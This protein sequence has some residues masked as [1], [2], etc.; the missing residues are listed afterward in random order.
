[1]SNV[2]A[3]NFAVLL[4]PFIGEVPEEGRPRFLA[5]L[6]RGAAE[7]YRAWAR[8]LP[9]HAGTLLAC[10]EREDEIADRVEAVFPVAAELEK[11]VARPLPRARDVYYDVFAGMPVRDQL[12]VQADAER[13]G[14]AAWR[15]L[16]TQQED[17][18]VREELER[19]ARLE[20]ASAE[21]LE[22]LPD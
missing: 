8:E 13:Q 1:M 15:G 5:L 6:E 17:A 3:P 14:A 10:A 18:A 2:Q 4:G 19:C 21:A 16:A 9:E 12:A 20:E 22:A 11:E 7:R